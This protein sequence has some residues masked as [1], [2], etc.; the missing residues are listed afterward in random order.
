MG[1]LRIGDTVETRYGLGIVTDLTDK[2]VEVYLQEAEAFVTLRPWDVR[3]PGGA[4]TGGRPMK[5]P[6]APRRAPPAAP[7]KPVAPQEEP[8]QPPRRVDATAARGEGPGRPSM[9]D[10]RVPAIH[11][12]NTTAP[13]RPPE[14]VH[15]R[16]AV[17]AL[18]FGLVPTAR[19]ERLTVGYNALESWIIELLPDTREGRPVAAEISG[20][21][22][23]GKSH[24]CAV[25]RHVA[26]ELN[27]IVANVEVDGRRVTLANP[28]ILLNA[29]TSTLHAQDL[30]SS[31]PIVELYLRALD[32]SKS[33]LRTTRAWH[34]RAHEN[35]EFVRLAK[36]RDAFPAIAHVVEKIL[37]CSPNYTVA[38]ARDEIAMDRVMYPA[39]VTLR[40]PVGRAVADRPAGFVQALVA[41]A[42]AAQMAG[43]GGFV[44]TID[45]FEIERNLQPKERDR[46]R[47]L[48]NELSGFI[49]GRTDHM[50]API[51][52]FFAS[53]GQDGHAGDAVISQ[54]IRAG[55]GRRHELAPLSPAHR[56][57]LGTEVF[58]LYADV[59][60]LAGELDER[61]I[62]EVERSLA[63]SGIVADS[64]VT[65][66]FIKEFVASLDRAFGPPAVRG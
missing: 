49:T 47:S 55:D 48:I 13:F 12:P 7:V 29:L 50:P 40:P 11:A 3:K 52:V 24:A 43:Y 26:R 58:K 5:P 22:G 65:R 60:G 62:T 57:E 46:V 4:M 27:Y 44:I 59:Y 9:P 37:S 33:P 10:P 35:F 14:H 39:A 1:D 45:E 42:L 41:I 8:G 15:L 28:S 66:A 64:G 17:E 23:T 21:F 54:L 31:T 32:T 56:A 63:D 51:A 38:Q 53:V 18:R 30:V 16:Q 20:P 2:G 19:L 34:D 6:V 36:S 25:V 61:Q